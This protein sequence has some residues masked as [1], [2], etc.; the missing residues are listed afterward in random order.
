MNRTDFLN[1]DSD[2]IVF[3][4]TD[5]LLFDLSYFLNARGWLQLYFLFIYTAKE[6][7]L[8]QSFLTIFKLDTFG[9]T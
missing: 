1:A 8:K 7:T 5:I 9:N 4:Y 6:T 3:C 2:A